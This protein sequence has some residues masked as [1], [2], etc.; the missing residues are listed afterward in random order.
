[1]AQRIDLMRVHL[2]AVRVDVHHHPAARRAAQTG[3]LQAFGVVGRIGSSGARQRRRTQDGRTE[4]SGEDWPLAHHYRRRTIALTYVIFDVL[5]LEGRSLLQ[6]P[7]S[8]RR[9]ELEAL[10]LNGPYWQTPETFDDGHALFQAVCEWELEGIVAKRLSGRYVPGERAWIK[11]KNRDYW[12]YELERE[13]AIN[14]RL[15]RVFV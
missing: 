9:A 5:S 12:R 2:R 1:M 14:K 15:Q 7:Y 11:I 4:R 8:E 13:S 10:N 3:E 6:A